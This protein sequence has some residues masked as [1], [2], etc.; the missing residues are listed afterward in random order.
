MLA[1]TFLLDITPF[2]ITKEH[3]ISSLDKE[4]VALFK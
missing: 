1:H 3:D 4:L 2:N